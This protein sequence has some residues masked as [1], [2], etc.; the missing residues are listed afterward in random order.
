MADWAAA[1]AA[2]AQSGEG[3]KNVFIPPPQ[4][5]PQRNQQPGG[6]GGADP[7]PSQMQQQQQMM[8]MAPQV[9]PGAAFQQGHHQGRAADPMR[10]MGYQPQGPVAGAPYG[11]G[12]GVL[13]G[14]QQDSINSTPNSAWFLYCI[15]NARFSIN[16]YLLIYT[17][18]ECSSNQTCVFESRTS[19]K[20]YII[21]SH[22]VVLLPLRYLYMV[23]FI[24]SILKSVSIVALLLLLILLIVILLTRL[25]LHV[26]QS[27]AL[28]F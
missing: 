26:H 17:R 1:A 16:I 5:P 14:R 25:L 18:D 24:I 23:L 4:P 21:L 6:W 22:C 2:W 9:D 10:A 27:V 3:E 11:H 13:K 15:C 20:V 7:H 28:H 19:S 12:G 8:W